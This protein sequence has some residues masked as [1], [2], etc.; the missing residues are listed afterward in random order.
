LRPS[1]DAAFAACGLLSRGEAFAATAFGFPLAALAPVV[2]LPLAALPVAV[3]T[4][5][6][7][8][9]LSVLATLAVLAGAAASFERSASGSVMDGF[10]AA[11]AV[12]RNRTGRR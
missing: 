7:P 5:L 8:G 10:S 12:P 9:L 4:T 1:V 2:F 6:A 11:W 3:L